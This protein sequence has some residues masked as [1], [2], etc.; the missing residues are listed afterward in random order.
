MKN[1]SA[2]TKPSQRSFN[3]VALTNLVLLMTGVLATPLYR[4]YGAD[5]NLTSV[6][7]TVI[8]AAY[9]IAVVPTLFIFGPIGDKI[10]RKRVLIT[11]VAIALVSSVV[12]AAGS[13]FIWLIVGRAL[14]G[15]AVGAASGN[16][17]AAMVELETS[18]NR[19]RASQIAGTSLFAGL[20]VGPLL[21]GFTAEYLPL[22][23]LLVFVVDFAVLTIVLGLLF[24]VKEPG[25]WPRAEKF[26]MRRPS[27]PA[28]IRI[29]FGSATLSAG[30]VFAMSGLYFSVAPAYTEALLNTSNVLVGGAVTSVMVTVSIVTQR[31]LRGVQARKLLIT[32]QLSLSLGLAL[33]VLA[34]TAASVEVLVLG[35]VISG[36]AYGATFLGAVAIVNAV[37]P[38]NRRGDITSTFYALTYLALGVPI[39]GLGF[40]AQ[41]LNLFEAVQFFVAAIVAI[42][43]VHVAWILLRGHAISD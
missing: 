19:R 21:S 35:A 16:A 32:G 8:Y 33:M 24:T 17:T 29:P 14:Q 6:D 42:A 41:V 5:F 25:Q 1:A 28:N 15:I 40:A 10:G 27:I 34:H 22:P 4:I 2:G 9:A 11:S 37:S 12:F 26:R 7:L 39:I 31:V 13:G 3:I 30:L 36:F 43:L 38:E 18:G 20:A 23:T